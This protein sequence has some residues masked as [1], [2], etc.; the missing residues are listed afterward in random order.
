[1]KRWKPKPRVPGPSGLI[2][3]FFVSQGK[4]SRRSALG[5]R[6]ADLLPFMEEWQTAQEIADEGDLD[7]HVVRQTL[8]NQINHVEWKIEQVKRL[9]LGASE[10]RSRTVYRRKR[11]RDEVHELLQ[12]S[13]SP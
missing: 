6:L 4:A 11:R 2:R 1:M 9:T 7:I 12:D 3:D 5:E 13:E 10:E 8:A